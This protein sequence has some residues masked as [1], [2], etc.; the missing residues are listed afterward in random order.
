MHVKAGVLRCFFVACI[1]VLASFVPSALLQRSATVLSPASHGLLYMG[2]QEKEATPHAPASR[3]IRSRKL[4]AFD[5]YAE[6]Q[7]SPTAAPAPVAGGHASNGTRNQ[8]QVQ[9]MGPGVGECSTCSI[10]DIAIVQG[11]MGPLPDGTPSFAVQI[12]NLCLEGCP[13]ADIHVLC[14]LRPALFKGVG[15][16]DCL[17]KGG[18]ALAAGET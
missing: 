9:C 8:F 18:H 15:F 16:D 6:A 12:L 5:E 4:L 2:S 14:A 11:K 17:V 7:H 10:E 1:T 3:S 13:I